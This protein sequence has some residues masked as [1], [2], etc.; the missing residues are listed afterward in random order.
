LPRVEGKVV[1]VA[2][3]S[4]AVGV[5]DMLGA[6]DA[7]KGRLGIWGKKVGFIIVT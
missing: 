4:N 1:K 2:D 6:R 7:T 5:V 3:M